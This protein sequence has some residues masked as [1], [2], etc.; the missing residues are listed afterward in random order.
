MMQTPLA[1]R[2][3]VTPTE[4]PPST[5]GTDRLTLGIGI[6][7]VVLVV[8]GIAVAAIANRSQ[9]LPPL[10]TPE[11]VTLAYELDIQR[12]EAD[13]AWELL[14]TQTKAGTSRQ[15][16]LARAAHLGRG[17][18]VRFAVENVRIDGTT[19][20]LDVVRTIPSA[21]FFGLGAGSIT[22]RSPVTLVQEGAEW[23]ISVP[24]EP[25]VIMQPAGA[26]P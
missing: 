21:G 1:D 5:S 20:H 25:F 8:I 4:A 24:S 13:R 22:D 14:S 16:F 10:T 7:V 9:Q 11:G 18:D 26:R 19:A 6:G 12:G 23:R 3:A 2:P 15:E 17:G